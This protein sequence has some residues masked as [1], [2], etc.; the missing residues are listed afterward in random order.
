LSLHL[1]GG[2]ILAL[3]GANGG[4]KTTSLRL[5]SGLLAADAGEGQ[6]LGIDLRRD[7]RGIRR[8]VGYL[9]Q[10]FSLYPTLSVAENLRFRA[11]VYDLPVPVLAVDA[12]I[13]AF[14]LGRFRGT[15]AGALSGG[16]ARRLQFAAALIHRPRLVLL[17]EPT[18]GLDAL[19]RQDIWRRIARLAA[20]GVGVVISTH[21]LADAERC[22]RA[23]L[24]IEGRA[25]AAGTPAE[26]AARCAARSFILDGA[27]G[28]GDRIEAIG[29]VIAC[30]PNETGLRILALAAA[31]AELQGFADRAGGRLTPVAPR[32]E[33]AVMAQIRGVA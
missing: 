17:D 18:S 31:E 11:E 3:L 28:Q 15:R 21:D 10:R 30:H 6:V 8:Q 2:E 24:L 1:D 14:G 16:W 23:L 5:L 4:G 25:A 7:P 27:A 32:L 12:A 20:D 13:D 22:G 9:S 19:A 29:G 26:L 33:D